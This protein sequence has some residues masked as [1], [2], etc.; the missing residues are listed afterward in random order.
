LNHT[1]QRGAAR[2]IFRDCREDER[3]IDPE[4]TEHGCKQRDER[5]DDAGAL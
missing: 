4:T 3:V 1:H 5:V 2:Q